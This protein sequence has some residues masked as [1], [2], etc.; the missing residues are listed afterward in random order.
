MTKE[1]YIALLRGINVGKAK[2]VSMAKLRQMFE[3]L[4]FEEPKTLL[5]SGNVVFRSAKRDIPAMEGEL[6]GAAKETFGFEVT[7][8]VRTVK[9]LA[10]AISRNPFE[11][12][13]KE[14]PGHLLVMFLKE[15]ADMAAV[16]RVQ[17]ANKGPE[18]VEG[19]GKELF[20]YYPEGVGNSKLKVA[21]L[22]T[23][24]NWNTVQKLAAL[25]KP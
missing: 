7:F 6:E 16:K 22:G 24:R 1:T 20:L 23:A 3:D 11:A 15:P 8:V 9:E 14:D 4:G 18:K 13:A 5:L 25:A 17:D 10:D 12:E 19:G 21:L 2:Q